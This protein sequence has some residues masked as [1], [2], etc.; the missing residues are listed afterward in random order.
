MMLMQASCAAFKDVGRTLFRTS[1]NWTINKSTFHQPTTNQPTNQPIATNS[2]QI[3]SSWCAMLAWC[4]KLRGIQG[5]WTNTVPVLDIKQSPSPPLTLP[6]TDVGATP[7]F[8]IDRTQPIVL[9]QKYFHHLFQARHRRFMLLCRASHPQEWPTR[10]QVGHFHTP[11][12]HVNGFNFD[13]GWNNCRQEENPNSFSFSELF[14]VRPAIHQIPSREVS[15]WIRVQSDSR[16]A[17]CCISLAYGLRRSMVSSG[18][19]LPF[20]RGRPHQS[21]VFLGTSSSSAHTSVVVLRSLTFFTSAL[22]CSVLHHLQARSAAQSASVAMNALCFARLSRIL[23][24]RATENGS[25][26]S[27][28]QQV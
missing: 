19:D 25:L 14:V 17:G 4:W 20:R 7:H 24:F 27:G 16:S 8:I 12:F 6:S 15:S 18:A 10:K 22:V 13:F 1:I 26:M 21:P 11:V 9:R 5:F 23:C 28:I 2:N 3:W